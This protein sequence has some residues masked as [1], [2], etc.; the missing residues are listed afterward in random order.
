METSNDARLVALERRQDMQTRMHAGKVR[1]D[2]GWVCIGDDLTLRQELEHLAPP[3]AQQGTHVMTTPRGHAAESRQPAAAHQVK[4][5]TLDEV[6]RGVR[7]GNRGGIRFSACAI[8]KF[9]PKA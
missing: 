4:R 1:V 6:V 8:E 9:V 7:D 2:V 3:N 5:H